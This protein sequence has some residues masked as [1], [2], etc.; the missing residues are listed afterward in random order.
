MNNFHNKIW[1]PQY[2]REGITA[3]QKGALTLGQ[4]LSVQ[5]ASW[6]A[7]FLIRGCVSFM[8]MILPFRY[9]PFV[10]ILVIFTSWSVIRMMKY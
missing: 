8:G 9:E 1:S 7:R 10:H 6:A 5:G 4:L 3:G 2:N